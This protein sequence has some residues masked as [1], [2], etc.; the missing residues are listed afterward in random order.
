INLEYSS[1]NDESTRCHFCP[2]NCAR[3][4]IDAKTPEGHTARYISGFSCEKGTVESEEAMLALTKQRKAILKKYPNLVDYESKQ[5]FP[6]F[7]DPAPLPHAGSLF[8]DI[9]VE[10]TFLGGVRRVPTKRA[11]QRSSEDAMEKRRRMRIGIPRVL[12]VYTTGAYWRTYLETL[13]IQK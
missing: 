5:T 9:K 2:N 13:G 3:T 1:T 8:D 10:R 7:Y 6:H 4:F 11:F 12:N